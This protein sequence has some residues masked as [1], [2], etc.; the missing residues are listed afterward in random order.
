MSDRETIQY[1]GRTRQ[2]RGRLH[3]PGP[4]A[5]GTIVGPNDMAETLVLFGTDERGTL[6]GLAIV[7]DME[8]ARDR[9]AVHGPASVHERQRMRG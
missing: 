3:Y 8:R 7:D 1:E 9:A 5:P 6:V 2:V 4:P